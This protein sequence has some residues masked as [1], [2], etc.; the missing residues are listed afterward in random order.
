MNPFKKLIGMLPLGRVDVGQ[1]TASD[2]GGVTIALQMG[3]IIHVRGT[4]TVG[5]RVYVRN[6]AI[7][8]P[9]PD[10]IGVDIEV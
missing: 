6:G 5:S 4:A 3:G 2:G 9:A 1:V 7:D 10:L 8:G